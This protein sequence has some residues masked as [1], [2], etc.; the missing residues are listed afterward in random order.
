MKQLKRIT[1]I[2]LTTLMMLGTLWGCSNNEKN[3]EEPVAAADEKQTE[4]EQ[5][6]EEQA[7]EPTE[8]AG[9]TESMTMVLSQRDEFLST[10]ESGA[11][12][13]AKELG[14]K[15]STADAQADT[16]KLLQ[17]IES[18]RNNG[19]KAIIV[20]MVDAS[21]A[22]QCVEAAGDM[23]VVFVN[24]EPEDTSVLNEN[25]AY[26]GSDENVSGKFQGDWLAEY[27]KEQ[28]KDEIKYILINGILGNV[29]TT[30]RTASAIQALEDNG[31]AAIEATAPLVADWDR[32][33]AQ[34][35]IAPLLTTIEYDC[36][37][38]NND[39]MA[40]GAIE[41]LIAEDL[42]PTATPV[43]GIDATEDGRQAVK[44][45]TLAMTVFQ[46]PVGQGRGAMLAAQNLIE[47]KAVNDGTGLDADETGYILWVPFELVTSENVADYDNR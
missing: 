10:L 30:L 24:R 6:E 28:G 3:T 7:E 15:L 29:S 8:S 41:G 21:T 42:D 16:S 13:V 9:Q 23:K 14:I 36:I 25:V 35:M 5:M 32:A 39:A 17:F 46:D 45:G 12:E 33:A 2:L 20:N 19:E 37:I 22:K 47:G 11:L 34:D 27:F 44:E 18:A 31:I 1:A 38:S 40:L 4:E 26:V 43:V